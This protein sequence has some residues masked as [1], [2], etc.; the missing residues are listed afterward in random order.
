MIIW[1]TL[2]RR[3]PRLAPRAA[4]QEVWMA[5]SG[6]VCVA[7]VLGVVL[8]AA[9]AG[10]ADATL[11]AEVD[12]A[13]VWRG[14]TLNSTPV[15]VPQLDV[16]GLKLYGLPVVVR[17]RGYLNVGDEGG[18]LPTAKFAKIDLEAGIEL[19]RG[20]TLS[21]IEY[22][23][24]TAIGL[25]EVRPGEPDRQ[26]YLA[27]REVA[28]GWRCQGAFQPWVTVYRDVGEIDD[29]FV[30]FGVWQSFKL[31]EQTQLDLG[32]LASYAGKRYALDDG[33]TRAGFHN[34]DLHARLIYRPHAALTLT[35]QAAY[36]RT[37]RDSLPKQ[38][39]CFY[40]GIAASVRY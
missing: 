38:P 34:Y 1:L 9:S 4:S 27:T 32:P 33:A 16:R 39:V 8:T 25:R 20:F 40:G 30:E 37:F 21:Y 15:L 10:A 3:Q 6:R 14:I 31:S 2:L 36:T 7:T 29:F 5:G 12:S 11:G 13:H 18:I 22:A 23:F 26:N 28:L 17:V 24:P 35:F 19:P